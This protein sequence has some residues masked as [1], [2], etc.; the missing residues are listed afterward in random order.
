M[1]RRFANKTPNKAHQRAALTA[2]LTMRDKPLS[3]SDKVSL[4]RSYGMPVS[5]IESIA[6]NVCRGAA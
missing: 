6:A 2:L 1:T 3:D 5:E 4:S